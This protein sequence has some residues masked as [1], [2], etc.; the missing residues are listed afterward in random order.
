MISIQSPQQVEQLQTLEMEA[1]RHRTNQLQRLMMRWS[2]LHPYNVVDWVELKGAFDPLRLQHAATAVLVREHL[3]RVTVSE[4]LRSIESD[5][6]SIRV[7]VGTFESSWFDIEGYAAAE[8][9]R[10]FDMID[11]SPIRLAGTTTRYGQRIAIT[12]PHWL[13]DGYAAGRLFARIIRRYLGLPSIDS[14]SS[15][16]K[17]SDGKQSFQKQESSY[18]RWPFL[19][20]ETIQ[21]AVALRSCYSS[22]KG[23]RND[24]RVDVSFPSLSGDLLDRLRH[25]SRAN[26]LTVNDILLAALGEAILAETPERSEQARRTR[27]AIS[28]AVDLRQRHP[29][30]MH[31]SPGVHLG[32]FRV[33]CE[34]QKGR[35]FDDQL[36]VIQRQTARAKSKRTHCQS[37][38]EVAYSNW[39]WNKL[40]ARERIRH[41]MNNH[42]V[43]G[44]LSNLRHPFLWWSQDGTPIVEHY[45]RA[46]PTGMMTP[47]AI[48]V[49]TVD[50]KLSL[51]ATKRLSG[52]DSRQADAI[53]DRMIERMERL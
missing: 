33:I 21:S 36:Q 12:F 26:R 22:C 1:R 31:D 2:S 34:E 45:Q 7:S 23:D 38:A 16:E 29:E 40:P 48:G 20:M 46:V 5:A 15:A 8:L 19:A 47:L 32:F 9:N 11:Q 30:F 10:P 51:S 27:I 4:D 14:H 50:G 52:Y 13:W 53:V 18:R 6:A 42:P 17:L 37:L 41:F 35:T 24:L 44:G 39:M 3:S 49:T 28:S 25:F 43:A